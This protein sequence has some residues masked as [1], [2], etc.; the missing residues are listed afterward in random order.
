MS[1]KSLQEVIVKANWIIR[2]WTYYY[3]FSNA[4]KSFSYF[5]STIFKVVWR[6]LKRRH[7]KKNM[8]WLMQTCFKTVDKNQWVLFEGT[9]TLFNPLS[10][11]V[12]RYN[13]VNEF[14][15]PF[16]RKQKNYWKTRSR[17]IT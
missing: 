13:K 15:S 10:V 11:P 7:P 12:V 3:R 16:D 9:I 2:G 4:K 1:Y 17:T 6:L 8:T 5:K 14:L